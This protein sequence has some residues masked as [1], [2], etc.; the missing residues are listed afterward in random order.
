[1]S[2]LDKY[3]EKVKNK[4]RKVVFP[5]GN[6]LRILKTAEKLIKENISK[7]IVLGEKNQIL[8][9]AKENK[10]ELENVEIIEPKNSE[11]LSLLIKNY[12]EKRNV[13]IKIAER[14]VKKDLIFGGMMVASGYADCMV[15]GAINTTANVIQAATLTCG[16]QENIKTP[17]SFFIMQLPDDRIYFYAD[18]AVN[19]DPN[20]EQLADIGIS[21]GINYKK[22]MQQDPKIAFLSF[23]TKGSASH[24]LVEKVVKAVDIAKQKRPDLYID[25]EL[26][27]DSAVN[28]DVAKKK[29]KQLSEVAGKANVLIFP[30]LNSGNIGYKLTQYL[31]GAK[32]YGPILQGFAKPVSDLSRGAK[33]EDIIGATCI[34]LSMI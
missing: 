30:D 17:S 19:I 33:V 8:S 22:I 3:I 2:F 25:G 21:T 20:S 4:G 14:L 26:Q 27:L 1:M 32:A 34:L 31:A 15:A 12:S 23:S 28:E 16:Y 5:E 7:A 24:I 18:C 6:E 29:L 13:K 9:L 11:I 10:I